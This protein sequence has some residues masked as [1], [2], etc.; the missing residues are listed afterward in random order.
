LTVGVGLQALYADVRLRSS[1][2]VQIPDGVVG[3]IPVPGREVEADDWA[4]GATAGVIWNPMPGTRIGVGYRS[5]IKVN[6]DGTCTGFGLS[7]LRAGPT[8]NCLG[9]PSVE[10]ELTL[11]DLI[12][13]S[14][15]QQFGERWKISGTVEWT[16]WS[17]VGEQANFVSGDDVV[18]VFPLG[19]DDGWFFSGGVEYAWSPDTILRAGLGY[20]KSPISD[21]E[22]NVSLPDNDRV[23]L[24]AGFS[25][26]LS[27]S[28]KVDFGYSHLFVEDAPIETANP[29]APLGGDNLFEGEA[30][31]DIDIVTV[32]VTHN[33]GVPE[34]ELE[35]LK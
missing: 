24:S 13:A 33:F 31:G 16:N 9:N 30:T 32:G 26:K 5:N 8:Q 34:P 10:A 25:T 11:P 19:Y 12:T 3:T 6:A 35:P 28:T 2:T 27:E 21:E 18:D 14:F 1:N 7:N 4:F 23:W 22:R 20:E 15:S 29:F 17:R